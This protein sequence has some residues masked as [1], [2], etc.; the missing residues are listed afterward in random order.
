MPRDRMVVIHSFPVW[1]PQTQTWMYNQLKYLPDSVEAHVECER[2]EH[3]DQFSVPNIHCLKDV[4]KVQYFWEK[5]ARYS[6]FPQYRQYLQ[7]I[8]K[9]VQAG[10]LHSHFGHIGWFD[11]QPAKKAGIKHVVT[12]YGS[13]VGLLP[14]RNVEWRSRYRKLFD[15]ADLFLCEGPFMARQ[16][17][18]LGCPAEKVRV[19][20]LGIP[21]ETIP[22]KPRRWRA[23][24]PLNVLIAASFRVKKGIPYALES[25]GLIQKTVPVEI[26]IIGDSVS[27]PGSAEEKRRILELIDK[28]G[29]KSRTKLL[30]F[31]PYR[32][33]FEEAYKHHV[34]MSPS[35]T[36][37]DG[38]S[39]GGAPVTLIEMIATGM[40]VISTKHCDIPEVVQNGID[41]WLVAERDAAGLADKLLWLVGHA[42]H[43]AE[44]LASGRSHVEREFNAARQGG[45]LY[46]IYQEMLKK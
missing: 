44:M 18:G 11:L 9:T 3:L 12:Y 25:L 8:A 36:A 27:E 24:E 17:I 6:G 39:E 4:S 31:Q 16:L 26:T 13:D 2:T 28:G 35:V 46:E 38:D 19:H 5:A 14:T 22:F 33:V 1:L 40:P 7:K 32:A 45:R 29:L 43:W 37:P 30:G 15:Q 42:G 34:F 41:N 10:I 20:H 23:G 21:V